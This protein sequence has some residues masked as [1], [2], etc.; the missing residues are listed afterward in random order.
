MSEPP[1]TRRAQNRSLTLTFYIGLALFLSV[2][3]IFSVAVGSKR[4]TT[5]AGALHNADEALRAATVTRAQLALAVHMASVDQLVGTNSSASVA[6]S[7]SE[8]AQA[9]DDFETGITRLEESEALH[10]EAI[11]VTSRRFVASAE[12]V[13][14]L[15]ETNDPVSARRVMED[16]LAEEFDKL[17]ARLATERNEL[18]ASV[19]ASD[20]ML[21]RIGNLSRFLV[22]FFLP[23]IVIFVYRTLLHRQQKQA[24]VEKALEHERRF[25]A[26]RETFIANV[27]HE[28]RTPLTSI[29][30]LSALI[31]EDPRVQDMDHVAELIDIIIAESDDLARMV[32]DLL[33]TAR[34]DA[35]AL[36]YA[37]DDVDI[38]AEIED[39]V[40][41]VR[42]SGQEIE[43]D[44]EPGMARI[45]RLRFRQ[46]FRNLLS[47]ARKYGGPS[48]EVTGR[49][50]G[51]T[52][53]FDVIDDGPGIPVDLEASLFQRFIHQGRGTATQDS[54]GLGLS[55]VQALA[56]GMG[57]SISYSRH[58]GRTHFITRLP[59]VSD[60]IETRRAGE[61]AL[62]VRQ[63]EAV[64]QARGG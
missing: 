35:G 1:R 21:G 59:L 36:H 8:A 37:F 9:L 58:D 4:I 47:N 29:L 64:V 54:V 30:G 57:G 11:P 6:L 17:T 55:I 10:D 33:T 43:I 40:D 42:R 28:F 23:A 56:R 63:P 32:E 46:L 53:V 3:L 39:T 12:T 16:E 27:S 49:V 25:N 50:D 20:Q 14:D 26:A 13:T 5:D 2:G 62:E 24:E 44:C 19:V 31:S 7:L 45:D 52:Y 51:I 61:P 15:I 41:I 38:K 22:A 18:A 48:V 34:L 60:E